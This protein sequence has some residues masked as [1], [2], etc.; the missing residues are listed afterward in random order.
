MALIQG[1]D[2]II[3][4]LLFTA[5]AVSMN[6]GQD[7]TAGVLVGL[8]L[9]KFQI[10]L[11][12]ALLFFVWRRWRFTAGFALSCAAVGTLSLWLVGVTQVTAYARSLA[13]VSVASSGEALIRN[14]IDPLRMANL[15]GLI[16]AVAGQ[17]LSPTWV[18]AITIALSA[19]VVVA[20]A[21]LFP[22]RGKGMDA[23]L[24]AITA[25][26][27]VSYHF[28]I[29]DMSVLLIPIAVLLSR[30][31]GSEA[32]GDAG[33]RLAN[34]ATALMF[35]A[36]IC[37]W[38]APSHVYLVSLPLCAFLFILM[39]RIRREASGQLPGGLVSADSGFK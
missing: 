12:I 25:S 20:V 29:H 4:L 39:D 9:F 38:Y 2:S 1:Q 21:A 17:R 6:R 7:L 32:S 22:R 16:F 11:P 10:S 18:Q 37:S 24:V 19:A 5:A 26:A 27:V 36:P 23:F 30:W 8:G 31:I 15:R 35:V 34:R 33:G 14:A 28:L 13:S 3:L